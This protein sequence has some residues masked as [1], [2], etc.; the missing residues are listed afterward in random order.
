MNTASDIN[1]RLK[2]HSMHMLSPLFLNILFIGIL[3]LTEKK[4]EQ[5]YTYWARNSGGE[6]N[7]HLSSHQ[8][9]KNNMKTI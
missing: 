7:R 3:C 4:S 5:K 1:I 6:A 2:T 8:Y 9:V